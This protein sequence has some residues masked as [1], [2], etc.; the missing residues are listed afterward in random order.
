LVKLSNLL[1]SE[2]AEGAVLKD[3]L[4]NINKI[5]ILQDCLENVI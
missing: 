3:W 1:G 2:L 5:L 4:V